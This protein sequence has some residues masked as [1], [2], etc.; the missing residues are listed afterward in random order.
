MNKIKNEEILKK[1]NGGNA[2]PFYKSGNYQG[3]ALQC[4]LSLFKK[5]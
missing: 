3:N 1:I 5:C 4:V 2:K